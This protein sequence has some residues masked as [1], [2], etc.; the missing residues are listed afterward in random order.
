MSICTTLLPVLEKTV[1][2]HDCLCYVRL[3]IENLVFT[4]GALERL[5]PACIPESMPWTPCKVKGSD[6][7]LLQYCKLIS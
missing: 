6:K 4:R 1:S 5:V 3:I 7:D 2:L